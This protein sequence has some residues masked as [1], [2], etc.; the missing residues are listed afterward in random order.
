MD[1]STHLKD[2]IIEEYWMKKWSQDLPREL[3]PVSKS[4]SNYQPGARRETLERVIPRRQSAN[5][6]KCRKARNWDV[7][8]CS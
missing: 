5:W 2:R 1:K 6:I 8:F 3:L 4:K 7:L